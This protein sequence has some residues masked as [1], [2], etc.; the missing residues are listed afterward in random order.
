MCLD[1]IFFSNVTGNTGRFVEKLNYEN[2]VIQIPVKENYMF[3]VMN[4]YIL[5]VPTYGDPNGKGMVPHQVKKFLSYKENHSF[6]RGVIAAGNMNFGSEYG[7]AGDLISRKYNV[8]LLHK[9]ELAGNTEDVAKV[10]TIIEN[11]NKKE[12][13]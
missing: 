12:K 10:N 4:P 9:F 3:E 13:H 8:P 5:I 6:I 11:F 2:N 1:L 7:M